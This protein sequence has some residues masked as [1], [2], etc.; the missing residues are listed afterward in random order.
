MP[1]PAF[2]L[3]GLFGFRLSPQKSKLAY[4]LVLLDAGFG[5]QDIVYEMTVLRL[6]LVIKL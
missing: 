5:M 4:E 6:R 1:L 2:H 3:N